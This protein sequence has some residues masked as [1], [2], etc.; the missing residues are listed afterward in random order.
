LKQFVKSI[1]NC[2][3]SEEGSS[4]NALIAVP[5]K[6]RCR[7]HTISLIDKGSSLI[8]VPSKYRNLKDIICLNDDEGI[9]LMPVL[10]KSRLCKD[11]IGTVI[12]GKLSSSEQ[13]LISKSSSLVRNW[14]D[15][16]TSLI[17]VP[18]K[19][20]YL[21][22]IICLND[23]KGISLMPVLLKLRC[24]K[25][26]IGTVISGKL[27]SFEQPLISNLSS[28]VRNWIDEGT[29]L[30]AVPFRNKFCI[31]S[32]FSGNLVIFEQPFR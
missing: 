17:G 14:I 3:V 28:L 30:I 13:P 26:S 7:K 2:N 4:G 16:G 32:K 31:S 27:S 15:E 25:D 8:G 5:W 10:L 23:I 20:R 11:F 1:T 18:S 29:S 9:S 6:V 12:S 21:K 19:N 24:C 22:D